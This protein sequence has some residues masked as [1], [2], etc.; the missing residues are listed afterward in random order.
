MCNTNDGFIVLGGNFGGIGSLKNLF[1]AT[2]D[3]GLNFNLTQHVDNRI[4]EVLNIN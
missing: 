1:P 3:R 4:S 2:K